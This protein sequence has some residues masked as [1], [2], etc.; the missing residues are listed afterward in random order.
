MKNDKFWVEILGQEFELFDDP[1]DVVEEEDEDECEW[2][3]QSV[4]EMARL[5]EQGQYAAI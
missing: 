5:L 2:Q 1:C 3:N 4:D